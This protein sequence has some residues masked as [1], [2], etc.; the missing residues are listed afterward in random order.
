MLEGEN[1]YW[2]ATRYVSP[3]EQNEN[4]ITLKEETLKEERCPYPT[5]SGWG[6][7]LSV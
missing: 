7:R 3:Y 6:E 2:P 5:C 1:L 4:I